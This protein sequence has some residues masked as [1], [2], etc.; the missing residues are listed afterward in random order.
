MSPGTP[1]PR[2][3]CPAGTPLFC[4]LQT[5]PLC[6][7]KWLG[8]AQ[9]A[10][11]LG[12]FRWDPSCPSRWR[13]GLA[14]T[15]FAGR[16]GGPHPPWRAFSSS[17]LAAMFSSS[18]ARLPLKI[19][20]SEK[21]QGDRGSTAAE[22]THFSSDPAQDFWEQP[23]SNPADGRRLR[24]RRRRR[25]LRLDCGRRHHCHQGRRCRR[26]REGRPRRRRRKG[27]RPGEVSP[28]G[29]R[30]ERS[31]RGA[32]VAR[33][34][35]GS[36]VTA[37]ALSPALLWAPSPRPSARNDSLSAGHR[38]APAPA[39]GLPE[40]GAEAPLAMAAEEATARGTTGPRMPRVRRPG[41]A[42]P[43]GSCS[44]SVNGVCVLPS[45]TSCV[46]SGTLEQLSRDKA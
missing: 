10:R 30:G 13:G 34:P 29:P 4:A 2:H 38:V 7:R 14:G 36:A 15:G 22:S 35:R 41:V 32:R 45:A 37:A 46:R 6:P 27:R 40:E 19:R 12:G 31:G 44:R 18:M 33:L 17:V 11:I 25:R 28:R 39:N 5:L 1:V 3:L 21:G 9:A 23:R 24:L 16:S 43:A 20:G 42:W 26:W 8:A